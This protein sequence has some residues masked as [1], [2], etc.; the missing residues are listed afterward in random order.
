M[1]RRVQGGLA[2]TAYITGF[3]QLFHSVGTGFGRGF[4]MAAIAKNLATH[5]SYAN[6]FD[7]AITG[8]TALVPPLYPLFLAALMGIFGLTPLMA[9]VASGINILVNALIA[10]L[11][12]RL[13]EVVFDDWRPGAWAGLLWIVSMRLM[14][15]W[16]ATFT[17]ALSIVFCLVTAKTIGSKE[18][19]SW[20]AAAAGILGGLLLLLNPATLTV[21][22]AWAVY[23]LA[24]RRVG[25]R[26][27]A[28]Y[29]GIAFLA[30]ALCN[31]PWV[32]RNY[33]IWRAFVVRTSFGITLYSS[34]N[35]CAESS[36]FKDAAH[37]CFQA[38][39]PVA[40]QTEV[41]LLNQLGEVRYDRNR[42]AAA[43]KWIA[44]NP[45][46]FR[47]L[48]LAR[49]FEFWFP[50]PVVPPYAAY[51]MWI[52]TILSIPGLVLMVRHRNPVTWFL[53]IVWLAYPA[54]Y[55]IM[56][57]CDRYRYPILWTSMLPAGYCLAALMIR[58]R[59]ASAYPASRSETQTTG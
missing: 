8:P 15:Q 9:L 25:F 26:Y 21:F 43:W 58:W 18:R 35:S 31:V 34:N 49:I 45:K 3:Y 47:E 2:L 52:I 46:R 55:Y 28:R 50:E 24:E 12:P 36:L 33:G 39:H 13:S 5:G 27:A 23:L 41:Q 53:L 57:S 20:H 44:S 7:P 59:A 40:S 14:P 32:V 38:T 4:E 16:D 22:T 30:A 1:R 29:G 17:I 54:M 6:P 51:G 56:V 48:T 42:A 37:G 10:S 11:M 19:L